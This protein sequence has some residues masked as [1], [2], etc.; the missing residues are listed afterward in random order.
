[1]PHRLFTHRA[2]AAVAGLAVVALAATACGGGSSGGGSAATSSGTKTVR[3]GTLPIANGAPMYLGIKKG[4]FKD[5]GLDIKSTV[6]QT[7]NDIITGMVSG[8]YDVGFVGYISA[9]I[10][11]A[12]GVPV[13]VATAS[14]ATGTSPS[15]DWQV[16]V[17]AGNSPIKT[18]QDLVGKTISVNGL[19]GVAEVMIKAALDKAR[20]DW[21]T[22]KLI[23]VP[24]PD[25]P[26]AVAAGRIDAGYTS[27]PFVTT[28][29][30]Q[31]GK[32]AFAPQSYLAPDYPNGSY[33]ASKKVVASDPD[34]IKRF[35]AAMTKSLDYAQAHPDEVRAIIPTYTKITVDLASRMRLPVFQSKLDTKAI[36][37]QMGFLKKYG[38]VDKA[39]SAKDLI[40]K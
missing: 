5:Q 35:D 40:C 15:D 32:V 4:F 28:V 24:F 23:E 21:K 16:L 39:P 34:L 1:M 14:D 10:A 37:Q 22:I 29:L 30:D 17:A 25:V 3:I 2:V 33:A 8:D 11:A 31:G 7:G 18:P 20:V 36:D 26:A 12:K 9:G 13:C 6:L 19:G 38:L 27:E